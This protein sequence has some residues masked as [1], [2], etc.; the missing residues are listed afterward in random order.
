[1]ASLERWDTGLNPS[2]ALW[3]KDPALFKL[4]HRPQLLLGSDSLP[5]SSIC[6]RKAKKK[7]KKKEKKKKKVTSSE[8]V[9]PV[10]AI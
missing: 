9:F 8:R 4:Q 6:H 3:D 1:V 2:P 10:H 5:G 7:K